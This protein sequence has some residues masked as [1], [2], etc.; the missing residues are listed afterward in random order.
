MSPKPTTSRR[1]ETKRQSLRRPATA[2]ARGLDLIRLELQH[3]CQIVNVPL[4]HDSTS[5]SIRSNPDRRTHATRTPCCAVVL[6]GLPPPTS[7]T[8]RTPCGKLGCFW[9][10]FW[11]SPVTAYSYILCCSTL[12]AVNIVASVFF[13]SFMLIFG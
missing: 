4:P 9:F 12:L 10:L 5:G 1:P 3:H 2:S 7:E 8:K 6:R 11:C 13:T